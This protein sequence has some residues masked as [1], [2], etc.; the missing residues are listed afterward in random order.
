MSFEEVVAAC[1]RTAWILMTNAGQNVKFAG[2]PWSA[3][4]NDTQL[5]RVRSFAPSGF[6]GFRRVVS[7]F[8]AQKALRSRWMPVSSRLARQAAASSIRGMSAKARSEV[9]NPVLVGRFHLPPLPHH[10]PRAQMSQTQTVYYNDPSILYTCP[11]TGTLAGT[12]FHYASC[13]SYE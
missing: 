2:T 8:G 11:P 10:R 6:L 3:S 9:E 7:L 1:R 13:L 12:C 4:Y 5:G